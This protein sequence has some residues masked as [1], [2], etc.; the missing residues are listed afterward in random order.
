MPGPSSNRRQI[1]AYLIFGALTTAVNIA[2]Y[3][4]LTRI[5]GVGYEWS[6]VAAWAVSVAFAFVT[7]KVWVFESRSMHPRV[8]AYETT[9]FVA[10][11][12]ASGLLDLG[13]MVVLVGLVHAP[14][15][16]SKVCVNVVVVIAN[17]LFS[18]LVVFRTL[19]A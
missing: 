17:Y 14:D 3:A 18:R 7:N 19:E 6:N 8:L 12:I 5:A 2:I 9:T 16:W 11:R 4:T 13:L 10:S 1:S 15:L